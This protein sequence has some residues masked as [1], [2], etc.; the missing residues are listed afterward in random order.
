MGRPLETARLLQKGNPPSKI[1][2]Q[3]GISVGSVINYLE[4]AIGRG[5]IRRSDIVFSIKK[6][7]RDLIEQ[8]ID[9][10]GKTTKDT[11]NKKIQE[12]GGQVD[13][14]DLEVYLE[15]RDARVALGDMYELIRDIELNLHSAIRSALV[16]EYGLKEE[17]WWRK[18][19][20]EKIRSECA[21]ALE[22]DDEPAKEKYCYTNFIDL[23]NIIN[24]EQ[25]LFEKFLP[26]ELR[27]NRKTLKST[28][29]KLNTIRNRVM[30]PIKNP[31]FSEE[32][33]IFV[34]NYHKKLQLK[35]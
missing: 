13:E 25:Q 22:K 31:N 23:Y 29:Y 4:T 3:L 21:T 16:N 2:E 24:K 14:R 1:A 32:D 28:L 18:G 5:M 30:H 34:R 12:V 27:S 20:P 33:F 6:E 9:K 26:K 19:V 10:T 15:M 8:A 7:S 11:I 17:E 35:K